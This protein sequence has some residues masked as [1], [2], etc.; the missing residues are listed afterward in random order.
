MFDLVV[1]TPLMDI[2]MK[3]QPKKEMYLLRICGSRYSRMDQV[4]FMKDNLRPYHFNLF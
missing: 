3:Y 2:T 1:N 4:K